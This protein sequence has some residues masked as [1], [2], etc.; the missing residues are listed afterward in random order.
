MQKNRAGEARL[1]QIVDEFLIFKISDFTNLS[2][3]VRELPR[4]SP[5]VSLELF[6]GLLRSVSCVFSTFFVFLRIF[7]YFCVFLRIIR[8][9]TTTTTTTTA[10]NDF[11]R[12]GR[13]RVWTA[14]R[15]R[16]YTDFLQSES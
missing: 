14:A 16:R 11:C 3:V 5:G 10:G 7:A 1:F 2:K 8:I 12:G 9:S 6:P 4:S 13:L 15:R